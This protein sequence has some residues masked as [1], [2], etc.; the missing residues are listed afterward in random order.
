MSTPQ[1]RRENRRKTRPGFPVTQPFT[2]REELTLYFAGER[3]TCL[4]CGKQYKDVGK[5]VQKIHNMTPDDYRGGYGIPWRQ[6]L[7]CADTSQA[8][9]AM[10]LQRDAAMGE[11]AVLANAQ[12]ARTIMYQTGAHKHHRPKCAVVIAELIERVKGFRY[13]AA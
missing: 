10:R 2:T 1:Q 11:Q 3:L 13:K 9:Q 7:V 6:G 4:L 5:H 8:Y 12:K